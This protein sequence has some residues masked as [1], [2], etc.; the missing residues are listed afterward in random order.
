MTPMA[1]AGRSMFRAAMDAVLDAWLWEVE[2]QAAHRVPDPVDYLEMRRVTFGSPMTASPARMAHMDVVP[3]AVYESAAMQSLEAAAFDC[4]ALMNDVYSYQKEVEYEGELL[5]MLVVTETFFGCD[6][7]TALGV[8]NDL[9]TSRMKQ[10]EHV[11]ADE[12]P[13]MYRDF[14][15]DA[16]AR[17]ALDR[18]AEELKQWMAGIATWH[19]QT[20]RYREEDLKRHHARRTGAVVAA[21]PGALPRAP[22]RAG[23]G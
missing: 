13:V 10:F 4:S 18:Y 14:G 22:H 9:M 12:F 6:Y 11:L 7:P 20:R 3:E 21:A 23:W 8:V 1:P 15:L 19:A 16:A 2:N 5:N 17:A